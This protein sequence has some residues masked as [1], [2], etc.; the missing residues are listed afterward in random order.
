MLVV[1]GVA[2]TED[3]LL[4]GAEVNKSGILAHPS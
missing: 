1:L 3:C 4:R 2:L